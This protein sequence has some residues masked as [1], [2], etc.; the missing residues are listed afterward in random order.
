MWKTL[1][2]IVL[3]LLFVCSELCVLFA[4]P[5]SEFLDRFCRRIA[6]GLPRDTI[7]FSGMYFEYPEKNLLAD[8]SAEFTAREFIGSGFLSLWIGRHHDCQIRLKPGVEDATAKGVSRH[9]A[10]LNYDD[11][12]HCFY[13]KDAGSVNGIFWAPLDSANPSRA[14]IEKNRR[15]DI[16]QDTRLWFGKKNVSLEARPGKTAPKPYGY[17]APTWG[18]SLFAVI[19]AQIFG[20]SLWLLQHPATL[21]GLNF[22]NAY[23]RFLPALTVTALG[24]VYYRNSRTQSLIVSILFCLSPAWIYYVFSS[25][26]PAIAASSCSNALFFTFLIP[27]FLFSRPLAKS[28]GLRSILLTLLPLLLIGLWMADILED[29]GDA[30]QFCWLL[31]CGFD[32]VG[33]LLQDAP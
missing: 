17:F 21:S 25:G 18:V 22:M 8:E 16:T 1:L 5:V 24:V 29:F 14:K 4:K 31:L 10:E 15:F 13:I 12:K 20:A 28:K 11:E 7:R 26:D 30:I 3:F 32:G 9:H 23:T 27:F 33:E 6:T 2:S 19:F